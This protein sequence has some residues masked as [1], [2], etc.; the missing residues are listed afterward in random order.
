MHGRLAIK[1]TPLST[2]LFHALQ[3]NCHIGIIHLNAPLVCTQR[4]YTSEPRHY[5]DCVWLR[6]TRLDDRRNRNGGIERDARRRR[7]LCLWQTRP[8]HGRGGT[9][10]DEEDEEEAKSKKGS[11]DHP[12]GGKRRA[13]LR[14]VRSLARSLELAP[15]SA[16]QAR[17]CDIGK[18]ME[19]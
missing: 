8:R 4:R 6:L 16:P 10:A 12:N 11:P 14:S 9:R 13:R 7:S 15:I 5:R 19:P 2:V 3:R 17:R 18:A 1:R